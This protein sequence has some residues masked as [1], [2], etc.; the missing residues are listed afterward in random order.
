LPTFCNFEQISKNMI[1][2]K[3]IKINIGYRNQTIPR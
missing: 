1:K 3:Y 2:Y